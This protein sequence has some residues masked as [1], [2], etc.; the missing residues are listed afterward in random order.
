M[1]VGTNMMKSHPF[2]SRWAGNESAIFWHAETRAIYEALR[3]DRDL[4]G[5]EIMVCRVW[6]NGRPAL[7]K[8]CS[9][10]L[11]AIRHFG[12]STVTYTA[13]DG[14]VQVQV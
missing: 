3:D 5:A 13:K 12:I 11:A 9:G 14:W 2:Q 1:Y 7:A 10:C 6:K 4:N 8:P